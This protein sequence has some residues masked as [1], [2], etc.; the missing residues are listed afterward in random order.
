MCKM[1]VKNFGPIKQGLKT[2]DGFIDFSKV[3]I[4]IG[5]QGTGKSTLAK[6]FSS[7]SWMEKAVLRGDY[8]VKRLERKGFFQKNVLA[9]HRMENYVDIDKSDI[10]YVGTGAIIHWSSGRL[11]VKLVNDDKPYAMPQIM[12]IPAERNF[13]SYMKNLEAMKLASDSLSEF[14]IEFNNAK[15]HIKD[16]FILPINKVAIEY[17]KLNDILNVKGLDKDGYKLRLTEASSGFQSLVPAL[18]VTAYLTEKIKKKTGDAGSFNVPHTMSTTRF[19]RLRKELDSILADREDRADLERAALAAIFSKYTNDSLLNIVEEPEQNLFP[20][21]Q[22]KVLESLLAYNNTQPSN[23]LVL[24]THS[25]YIVSYMGISAQAHQLAEKITV[26]QSDE[27]KSELETVISPSAMV[28]N[29]AIAIYQMNEDGS[30]TKL[31]S[32]YG[33]PSSRNQLNDYL[34]KGN[35]LFDRLLDIEDKLDAKVGD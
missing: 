5:N 8:D 2:D 33:I 28:S 18:L 4:F 26:A 31:V 30:L 11:S 12:Y 13:I 35:A 21:S 27:L 24:T 9:Y 6:L 3:T 32:E 34:R 17:D 29:Q 1:R 10:M 14:L 25:P 19:L 7:F 15:Q 23:K 20:D 22:W 16:Q